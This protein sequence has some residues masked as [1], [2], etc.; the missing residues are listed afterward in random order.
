MATTV[1]SGLMRGLTQSAKVFVDA[2]KIKL[3]PKGTNGYPAAIADGISV[4]SPIQ[5]GEGKYSITIS[6]DAPMAA[7]FEFGSGLHAEFGDK[8]TYRIPNAPNNG[9]AFPIE[10]WPK[11]HGPPRKYFAFSF[12]NHPGIAKRPFIKPTLD[13][14]KPEIINILGNNFKSSI[15]IGIREVWNN[16]VHP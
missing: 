14:T 13:V 12:V 10:R 5:E 11:Y 15:L 16:G 2:V 8:K 7:A 4:G 9:V 6:F 1:S 3:A